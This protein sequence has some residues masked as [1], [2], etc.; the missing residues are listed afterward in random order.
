MTKPRVTHR[1]CRRVAVVPLLA[2]GLLLAAPGSVARASEVGT[3]KKF[4]IGLILGEPTGVTLKY[5]FAERHA[6][7]GG[8]GVGWWGGHNFHLHADYTYNAPVKNTPDFDFKLFIGGG[9]KFFFY[10]Y[11]H[12]HPV[13]DDDWRDDDYGR[14]GLGIR[15]PLGIAF[16]L[17]KVPLD[18]FLEIAPGFAFLPWLD[19]FVDGGLGV[20]YYF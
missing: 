9:L 14:V 1:S 3:S 8:V 20:R 4:G 2:L 13:W 10:Y 16:H 12:Y 18:V 5:F 17:N 6:I 11:G 19:G 15:V 7:V